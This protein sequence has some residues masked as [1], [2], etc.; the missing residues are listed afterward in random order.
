MRCWESTPQYFIDFLKQQQAD[1]AA[2]KADRA[3]DKADR[4]DNRSLLELLSKKLSVLLDESVR[5]RVAGRNGESWAEPIIIQ[6]LEDLVESIFPLLVGISFDSKSTRAYFDKKN[7]A[8]L[9]ARQLRPYLRL[10]LDAVKDFLSKYYANTEKTIPLSKLTDY[11]DLPGRLIGLVGEDNETWKRRLLRL[12]EASHLVNL[13][14]PSDEQLEALLSPSGPGVLLACGAAKEMYRQR[15]QTATSHFHRNNATLEEV[16][17]NHHL[18][19]PFISLLLPD[20][21]V[22]LKEEIEV[23]F[24]ESPPSCLLCSMFI[25]FINNIDILFYFSSLLLYYVRVIMQVNASSL[26]ELLS[27]QWGR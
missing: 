14:D 4:V 21:F 23:C 25:H 6:S 26:T 5:S 20:P 17:S 1:R 3:A 16:V 18:G 2:D 27:Y 10:Y 19:N 24:L 8:L 15:Q 11:S 7:F 12:K 22:G 9:L 13:E